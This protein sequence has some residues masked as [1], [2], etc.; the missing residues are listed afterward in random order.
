MKLGIIGKPQSGKTTVFNAATGQQIG[1]GDFSQAV[2][3]GVVK[4]PDHRLEQLAELV[5]PK[6][7]TPAEIEFIDAPGLSGKGKESAGLEFSAE[8]RQAEAFITVLDAFSDNASPEADLQEILDEMILLDQ[9]LIE[10][11]I[12]RRERKIKL[13]GDKSEQAELALLKRCLAT[14]EEERP[15]I[16]MQLAPEEEK[17]LRGYQFL[18]RKPLLIV[19]NIAESDLA[20]ADTIGGGF[21]RFVEP[22]RRELTVLCGKIEAEL[23]ALDEAERRL[24]MDDIGISVPAVEQLIQKAYSLLGLISFLTAGEPEVRAWTIRRGTTAQRAAGVIHSDIERGFIRAEVV[25]F[26]DYITYKTHA[27][28]KAAGKLRLE[29]KEYVVADGDVILFRFNV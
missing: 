29:G 26:D 9:A 12:D 18:S 8:L 6:K 20:Q 17:M 14:L 15:L 28:L 23:V 3:R 27:A 19:L 7:I 24:F 21:T 4:V 16:D 5:H 13:T 11:N 25:A 22:G 1:V 2:H 10:T